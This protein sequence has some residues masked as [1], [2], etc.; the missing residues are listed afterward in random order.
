M[1]LQ[2]ILCN[3]DVYKIVKSILHQT[4]GLKITS[5]YWSSSLHKN[6]STT[7]QKRMYLG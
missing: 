1:I 6:T 2:M 5:K 7:E 4:Y 3:A